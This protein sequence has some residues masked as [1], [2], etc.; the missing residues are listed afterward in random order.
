MRKK[1]G[2]HLI[3][4][5]IILFSLGLIIALGF[6]STFQSFEKS[7]KTQSREEQFEMLGEIISSHIIELTQSNATGKI[8]FSIPESIGGE[9]YLLALK[10]GGIM[11]QTQSHQV[12]IT[13]IYGIE[14][15]YEMDG[16]VQSNYKKAS[17]T[18]EGEKITLGI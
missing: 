11:I 6:F 7:A 14:E 1:K 10:V 12:H 9:G 2:Q 8:E 17:V 4:E 18:L 13:P 16:V 15:K 5:E 3:L